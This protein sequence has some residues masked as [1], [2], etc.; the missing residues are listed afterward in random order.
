[1]ADFSVPARAHAATPKVTSGKTFWQAG[2][3]TTGG[4]SQRLDGLQTA[5]VHPK[6]LHS[7]ATSHEWTF[8]AIAELLDN[9]VDE[10]P[11]G[12]TRVHVDV[13]K[14]DTGKPM[15][16]VLDN[17]GGMDRHHLIRMMSFGMSD[18]KENGDRIGQY[19]NGFKTSSIR[20]GADAL[21][22]TKTRSGEQSVG[23][24]S[25]SFLKGTG[26]EEV[27]VPIVSWNM[28]DKALSGG[29]GR[30]Q[31]LKIIMEWSQYKTEK[32]LLSLCRRL[33]EHGTLVIISNLW[34]NPGGGYELD[35]HSKPK[36]ICIPRNE[37]PKKK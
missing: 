35:F 1:M 29:S 22:V 7:N 3:Y 34:D 31:S 18:G 23:L 14:D 33:G 27:I 6:F 12:C 24:L 36:D 26:A 15:L 20:L 10:I 25:F 21:V 8:G 28:R 5:R 17:G 37:E 4:N 2:E 9:S 30:E 13:E 16:T 32:A 19:G 11:N